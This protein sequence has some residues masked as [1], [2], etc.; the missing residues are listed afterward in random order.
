MNGEGTIPA[1]CPRCGWE[2]AGEAF[3]CARCGESLAGKPREPWYLKTSVL[4]VAFLAVGPFAIP[5]VW[6]NP[7]FT[8]ARK[9]VITAVMAA[10]TAL[11]V[12]LMAYSLTQI[13]SY[14]RLVTEP[15]TAPAAH[16]G[17]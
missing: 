15:W 4:V 1:K 12:W 10:V 8:A 13:D 9:V 16:R 14:Y 17:E 5:L 2:A 3:F 11:L 7:R 6:V